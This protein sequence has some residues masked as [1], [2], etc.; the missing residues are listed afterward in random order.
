MRLDVKAAAEWPVSYNPIED[1]IDRLVEDTVDDLIT[2]WRERY[3]CVG[4]ISPIASMGIG[5]VIGAM[6]DPE[7]EGGLESFGLV[8]PTEGMMIG[9]LIG[10]CIGFAIPPILRSSNNPSIR[11]S[12]SPK[13]LLGKSPEYVE[14]YTDTYREKARSLRTK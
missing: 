13:R 11:P 6:I 10:G 14:F 12:L 7:S 9:C 2:S 8:G 3:G 4:C 5:F 1:Y